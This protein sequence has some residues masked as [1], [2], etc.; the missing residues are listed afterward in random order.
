MQ[1][2]EEAEGRMPVPQADG[3]SLAPDRLF[4]RS[5]NPM[6]IVD[7]RRRYVDA[8][9]AACLFFRL[10]REAICE[11]SIDDV[12]AP[13]LRP[14]LEAVWADYLQGRLS[15]D[16]AQAVR[17]VFHMPDGGRV[18]ADLS[19]IPD[20]RPGRHLAIAL[21]PPADALNEHLTHAPAATSSAL[22]NREREI[23][24]LVALGNTG[25]QIGAELFVSPATVQTHVVNA[26]V[27]LRAKNRAHGIAIALQTGELDLD[28]PLYEPRLLDS[29]AKPPT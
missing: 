9:P 12:T 26:L 28:H 22:T 15:G 29:L 7:D 20:Y 6:L 8:N 16:S 24:T 10:A 11:L 19:S 13:E 3:D 4:S 27:K 23:L 18:C 25:V 5:L 1:I 17:W 21:F 2:L 14:D